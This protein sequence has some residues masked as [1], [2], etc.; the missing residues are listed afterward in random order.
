MNLNILARK[1]KNCRK[2]PLHKSRKRAVPGEG[3]QNA[4][5]MFIGEAPGAEED[6]AGRPFVGRSG[7]FL[8]QLFKKNSIN[9]KKVFI[10]GAV[11]CHP[12]KNRNPALKELK[13]CRELYLDKQIKIIKPK[14]VV[15]LGRIALKSLLNE[16]KIKHGKTVAKNSQKYFITYHPAAGMRFPKIRKAMGKDFNKIKDLI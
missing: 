1:I 9:R 7:E 13:T 4:K 2:C 15:I 3:P 8:D 10:T 14:L 16:N 6:K 11:K 12:P 5:I